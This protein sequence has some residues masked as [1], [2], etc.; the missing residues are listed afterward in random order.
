MI[1]LKNGKNV[2]AL[3]KLCKGRMEM[4]N[5]DNFSLSK[6]GLFDGLAFAEVLY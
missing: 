1:I 3:G 4:S 2:F 5:A 6:H